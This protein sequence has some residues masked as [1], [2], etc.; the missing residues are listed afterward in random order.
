MP[1]M[2]ISIIPLGTKSV[3]VSKY[4]AGSVKIL[5]KKKNIKYRLTPMGTI[6]ESDSL[7]HLFAIAEQMHNIAFTKGSKRVVTTIKID[8]RRDK[9]LSMNGKIESVLR[10]LKP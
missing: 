2:E 4:V 9:T 10:K 6:I 1:V 3:S 8:D 5:K 7:K